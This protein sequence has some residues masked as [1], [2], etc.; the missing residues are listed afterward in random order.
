MTNIHIIFC[1]IYFCKILYYSFNISFIEQVYFFINTNNAFRELHPRKS[2]KYNNT[3][4][5]TVVV[6]V[7]SER[8]CASA[9]YRQAGHHRPTV[10]SSKM[11]YGNNIQTPFL[12]KGWHCHILNQEKNE[13]KATLILKIRLYMSF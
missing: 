1:K 12:R 10:S 9:C 11:P 6:L 8:C 3:K 13:K 7:G 4:T 2:Y 5:L